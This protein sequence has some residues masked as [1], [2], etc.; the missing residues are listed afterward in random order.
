MK[1]LKYNKSHIVTNVDGGW[2]TQQ[3]GEVLEIP[4]EIFFK[5]IIL[6][7]DRWGKSVKTLTM[8]MDLRDKIKNLS[9]NDIKE[10]K[11]LEL[12]DE[13]WEICCIIADEP[14]NGYNAQFAS[15]LLTH[16]RDLKN[17]SD[18]NNIG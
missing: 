7:D 13:E 12:T 16:V 2:V 18:I 4:F 10:N 17:A 14:S 5:G 15:A 3:N 6:V 8:L 1:Y 9:F 11:I